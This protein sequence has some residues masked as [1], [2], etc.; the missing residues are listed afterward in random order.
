[1]RLAGFSVKNYRALRDVEVPLSKFCCLIGENNAGK[2]SVLQALSLFFTGSKLTPINYYNAAEPIRIAVTFD[3]IDDDDLARLPTE[4]RS[5]VS[6]IVRNRS[7]VL[8]RRY[9][10]DGKSS[11]LRNVPTPKDSRFAQESIDLLLKGMKPGPALAAKVTSVFHELATK[12]KPGMS[13]DAV[14]QVIQELADALPEDQ[15]EGRDSPLP[16]A[17]EKSLEYLLPEA[18]YIP[19]VKDLNDDIKTSESTPFGK[20]LGVLLRT[21][22][23]RLQEY[24]SFFEG[25]N[26]KLNRVRSADGTSIDNRIEEVKQIEHHLERYVRENFTN[27]TLRLEIP[28]PEL[29]TVFSSARINADDGVDG[30]VDTKGDGLRR[31]VIFAVL[32]AHLEIKKLFE[33][34]R[35][36]GHP[37]AAPSYLLLFEEPEL[38][39]HPKGQ[40]KLFEALRGFAKD[41]HVIVTTHSPMFF[42]PGATDMFIKLRKVHGE[43]EGCPRPFT[44]AHPIDL[45][46]MTAKD[47]FQIICF[48]N[49]SAA[50][51]AD[52]V[53]L[54]EG[55]SDYL[56]LPHIA[57]TLNPAWDT[58]KVV[59]ARITGKGN[60]RRYRDF[61]ARFNV[62]VAVIAD[63]D[64]LVS[65]F[66]HVSLTSA[67]RERRSDLVERVDQLI[68]GSQRSPSGKEAKKAYESGELRGLWRRVRDC[69]VRWH[70][71]ECSY[72]DLAEAVKQFFSWDK[73]NER[74]DILQ[75]SDDERLMRLKHQLLEELRAEDVYVLERGAI[76][77]YYPDTV[78]GQDKPSRA[79]QF[80]SEVATRE[81]VLGCCGEQEFA[82]DGELIRENELLLIFRGIFEG[83]QRSDRHR[84]AR[85]SETGV[86]S[87]REGAD[88]S[89]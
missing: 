63:L 83:H 34:R 37:Q 28:P 52:T 38:F 80:C 12:V 71:G 35:S 84:A 74:Y 9:G 54:V 39:L 17:T 69:E 58:D 77:Q 47:Q 1:M 53:V 62:R 30:P 65:G 82:R 22:E 26:A 10:T 68:F 42:A 19:A 70:E 13:Q 25:L 16:P 72:D 81:A 32:R 48:E 61:F 27:V 88:T 76:E 66:E 23:P 31:A 59:F 56:V 33:S 36:D 85:D 79:Q 57:R 73:K 89:R 64:L 87:A 49:N 18:I 60:I 46:D 8:V 41:H 11:L 44:L 7:L 50:F 43:V 29:K 15:K 40:H 20:I 45:R 67:V 78:T 2:S 3:E 21:A 14:R 55:D 6:G 4:H 86:L 75:S 51:F 24:K 5:R